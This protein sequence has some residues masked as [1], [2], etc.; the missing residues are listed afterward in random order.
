MKVWGIPALT[1]QLATAMMAVGQ[2]RERTG[3]HRGQTR[4]DRTVL[5]ANTFR[6]Q[7]C[8]VFATGKN[9]EVWGWGHRRWCKSRSQILSLLQT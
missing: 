9:L 8:L 5:N 2:G 3:W 1:A 6:E 4:E 7:S